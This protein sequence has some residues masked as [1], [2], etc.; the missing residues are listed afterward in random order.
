M[1]RWRRLAAPR[2]DARS[3]RGRGSA[4]VPAPTD[5][6]P[7]LSVIGDTDEPPASLS[8]DLP[9]ALMSSEAQAPD[10]ARDDGDDQERV[11]A[12]AIRSPA[13]VSIQG[14]STGR[15]GPLSE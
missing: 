2:P 8:A 4:G 5:A 13:R 3:R 15:K 11:S 1:T 14:P 12:D 10:A 6:G 7:P 9:D